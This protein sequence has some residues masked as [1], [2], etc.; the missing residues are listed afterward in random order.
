MILSLFCCSLVLQERRLC[1]RNQFQSAKQS[2]GSHC[3]K[4]SE[5]FPVRK[6]SVQQL[7]RRRLP[8]GNT[9]PRSKL[10]DHG[11]HDKSRVKKVAFDSLDTL[12]DV[13]KPLNLLEVQNLLSNKKEETDN[14]EAVCEIDEKFIQTLFLQS[15]SQQSIDYDKDHL[16]EVKISTILS[17]FPSRETKDV[18]YF[19]MSIGTTRSIS[20]DLT[21]VILNHTQH[22]V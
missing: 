6:K 22:Y 4:T 10:G 9:K 14:Q 3:V 20:I 5:S 8:G 7:T 17:N 15:F 19:S 1:K 18:N 21:R 11:D 12:F 16:H 13:K 2:S